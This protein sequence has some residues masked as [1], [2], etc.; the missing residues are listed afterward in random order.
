MLAAVIAALPPAAG[1]APR[2]QEQML[3]VPPIPPAHPPTDVPAPVPNEDIHAPPPLIS[4]GP[5]VKATLNA[6][7]PTLPGGD[8]VPGTL[9]RSQEEQRRQFIPNPGVMLI[10]PLEK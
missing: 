7:P 10:V 6:Q 4:T 2:P 5:T 8:P 9:Y 1:A 3:P